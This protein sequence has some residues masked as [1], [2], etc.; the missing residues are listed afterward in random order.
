[1]AGQN[2][3]NWKSAKEARREGLKR[4]PVDEAA[5][6]LRASLALQEAVDGEI[7]TA[8][9]LL[10]DFET[11]QASEFYQ[12]YGL[13]A[14]SVIAA[15]DGDEENARTHLGDA[16][17]YFSTSTSKGPIQTVERAC[18]AVASHLPWTR[19][20]VRRLRRKWKLP[21]PKRFALTF[22][23]ELKN[24]WVMI[25]AIILAVNLVRGC[26]GT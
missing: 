24:K 3:E 19:G 20:S 10:E 25:F 7:E 1:M 11:G 8:R 4:F 22:P 17:S 14:W 5:P 23:E 18:Q 26:A 9:I 2:P 21:A 12:K 15:A 16:A 13:L 6:A